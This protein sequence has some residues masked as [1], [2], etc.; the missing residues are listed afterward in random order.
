[1]LGQQPCSF[2]QK[3]LP[4]NEDSKKNKFGRRRF[5]CEQ[6]SLIPI[7]LLFLSRGQRW[8]IASLARLGLGQDM[9]CDFG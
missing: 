2:V 6:C 5:P 4:N 8:S 3:W 9:V 7:G 1:M